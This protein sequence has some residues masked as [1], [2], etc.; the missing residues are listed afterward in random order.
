MYS[1]Y[2]MVLRFFQWAGYIISFIHASFIAAFAPGVVSTVTWL[3][4]AVIFCLFN[5]IIT[6]ALIACVDLL[7][8]IETNTRQIAQKA[9]PNTT[10][11]E[12]SA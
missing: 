9:D 11:M 10:T 5:Y 4:I 12:N 6:Q 2:L 7:S 8:R 3:I 1:R